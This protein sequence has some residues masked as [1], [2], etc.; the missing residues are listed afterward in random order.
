MPYLD[1]GTTLD[2]DGPLNLARVEAFLLTIEN[3]NNLDF[4][5][6]FNSAILDKHWPKIPC[7]VKGTWPKA[8]QPII[9]TRVERYRILKY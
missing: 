7:L 9:L 5:I 6:I 3:G 4:S 2:A 8:N 1:N